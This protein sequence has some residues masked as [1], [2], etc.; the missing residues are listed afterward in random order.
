M[1]P[2]TPVLRSAGLL[3]GLRAL[4]Q[5]GQCGDDT[6]QPALLVVGPGMPGEPLHRLKL[7]CLD[8][9]G[10]EQ[11]LREPTVAHQSVPNGRHVIVLRLAVLDQNRLTQE[12]AN[13]DP[14]GA[15]NIVDDVQAAHVAFVAL[16]LAQPVF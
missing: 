3:Q 11:R 16:D 8:G 4:D 2:G 14:K 12:V 7:D 9:P 5:V 15:S 10:A 6:A 13:T 1:D